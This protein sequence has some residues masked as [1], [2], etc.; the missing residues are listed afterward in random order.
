MTAGMAK[1]SLG[2]PQPPARDVLPLLHSSPQVKHWLAFY[3]DK[4]GLPPDHL[5]YLAITENRQE[6]AE[7]TG[8]R[9]Q[10]MALGCYCYLPLGDLKG[11]AADHNTAPDMAE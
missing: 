4:L 10:S 5:R 6:F 2:I 11:A 9:L 1:N 8:K 7:W 3:W